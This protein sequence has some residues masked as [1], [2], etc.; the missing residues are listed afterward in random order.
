MK[1]TFFPSNF[2]DFHYC[3][4]GM[5]NQTID[6]D[7]YFFINTSIPEFPFLAYTPGDDEF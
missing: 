6:P 1:T 5:R 4:I 7:I 3:G 2:P